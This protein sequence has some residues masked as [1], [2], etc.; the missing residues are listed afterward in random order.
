MAKPP[1]TPRVSGKLALGGRPTAKP[2]TS[3]QIPVK[4]P[5]SA[6]ATRP[7]ALTWPKL[8]Q[9][10]DA[11]ALALQF[12]FQQSE[13]WPAERLLAAQLRQASNLIGHA[14][15]HVPFHRQRL[16][17][18][19]VGTGLTPDAFR[20]IP[21][22]SR[23]DI[24]DAGSDLFPR[25]VPHGHGKSYPVRS[26]GS[27]G[28]PIEVRGNDITALFMRA[29]T[30]RGHLWHGRDFRAKSVDIRT[31]YAPGKAPRR[32]RWAPVPQTG[33]VVRIDLAWTIADIFDALIAEDPHYV[34]THPY[35]L[36]AL[37]ERSREVG[38]K[39]ERLRQGRVFGEALDPD[40]RAIIESEWGISVIENY[41]AMEIGTIA[42]QCPESTNL[43][44][45][46]ENV[47]VEVLDEDGQPCGPGETGRVVIT[48]LN[49]YASPLIRYQIG[50]YAT[51][52][53]PC[54]CGRSLPVLSRVMGRQRNLIILP[55]GDRIFPENWVKSFMDIGDIRQFQFIQRSRLDLE[56]RLVMPQRLGDD[57]E[58]RVHELV[59]GKFGKEFSL[60]I[61]YCDE[62]PRAANGKFEDFRCEVEAHTKAQ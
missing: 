48:A 33:P 43:H 10:M 62:I 57:A 12:E 38:R 51:V 24:Q 2:S 41:S 29:M 28:R 44:V 5:T 30:M 61:T 19:P 34:Q 36:F 50:D 54:V 23:S 16:A 11:Q 47:L 21:L 37:V 46:A 60:A 40:V 13:R 45:Q 56:L 7:P 32:A 52:G 42:L 27:T 55:N 9:P 18:T 14:K 15:V 59:A 3:G 25:T 49:N 22:M 26:S 31:A 20:T 8:S 53:E 58:A 6:F 4:P 39:P 17:K 35:T 1:Q